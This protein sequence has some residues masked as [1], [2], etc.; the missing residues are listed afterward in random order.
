MVGDFVE[1]YSEDQPRV[2]DRVLRSI[3]SLLRDERIN[4]EEFNMLVTQAWLEQAPVLLMMVQEAMV[5]PDQ[6]ELEEEDK[7]AFGS[8][9]AGFF[10]IICLLRMLHTTDVFACSVWVLRAC[11][12]PEQLIWFL[13]KSQESALLSK[14]ASLGIKRVSTAIL[15]RHCEDDAFQFWTEFCEDFPS[16]ATKRLLGFIEDIASVVDPNARDDESGDSVMIRLVKE[17]KWAA[18][19]C[20]LN[21]A[22]FK[23]KNLSAKDVNGWSAHHWLCQMLPTMDETDSADVLPEFCSSPQFAQLTNDGDSCLTVRST[24]PSV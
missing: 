22:A 15:K 10:L 8:F 6:E 16:N 19:E 1:E 11:R 14:L 21:I 13:S 17:G 4:P 3:V 5:Y 7:Q 24:T 23:K 20:L 2:Y 12:T 18:V 9:Q